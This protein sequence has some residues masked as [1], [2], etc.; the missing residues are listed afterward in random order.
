MS[1]NVGQSVNADV[2]MLLQVYY[3]TYLGQEVAVKVLTAGTDNLA[4]MT[5][6]VRLAATFSQ[7]GS[8]CCGEW[9]LWHRLAT[10]TSL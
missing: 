4:Q 7:P 5:K 9:L 2:Y 1:V 8:P 6:E 3:G 10:D